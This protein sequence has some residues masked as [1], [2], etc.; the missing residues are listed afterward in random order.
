[1]GSNVIALSGSEFPRVRQAFLLIAAIAKTQ[2]EVAGESFF[3]WVGDDT[4]AS[5]EQLADQFQLRS[6]LPS[7]KTEQRGAALQVSPTPKR[8]R[9]S[10]NPA[11]PVSPAIPVAK[12]ITKRSSAS[13]LGE[14]IP[15]EALLEEEKRIRSKKPSDDELR[16]SLRK[17]GLEGTAGHYGV[18]PKTVKDWARLIKGKR[19][20]IPSAQRKGR[21]KSRRPPDAEFL[22]SLRERGVE[23][24]ASHYGVTSATI[25]KFW[26]K[27]V[28]G[29]KALI[30]DGRKTR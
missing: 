7:K 9:F 19:K 27:E 30:P 2:W 24:T 29:A 8:R 26:A 4:R 6:R 18:V 13:Y 16:K 23:G 14:P 25:K 1:M 3:V 15:V 10:F 17:L 21:K 11:P 5:V 22:Q 20:L 12:E 28:P